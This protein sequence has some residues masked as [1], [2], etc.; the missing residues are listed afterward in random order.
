MDGRLTVLVTPVADA[1]AS[2]SGGVSTSM[3]AGAP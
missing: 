1:V 2:A 3:T